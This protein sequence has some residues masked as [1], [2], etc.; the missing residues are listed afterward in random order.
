MSVRQVLDTVEA[1][2]KDPAEGLAATI[3]TLTLAVEGEDAGGPWTM[4]VQT[5]DLLL[6]FIPSIHD[7]AVPVLGTPTLLP[8]RTGYALDPGDAILL[9]RPLFDRVINEGAAGFTLMLAVR[10]AA[11]VGTNYQA[12]AYADPSGNGAVY[13][14]LVAG[15]DGAHVRISSGISYNTVDYEWI[16]DAGAIP[17][18]AHVV[19]MRF[20]RASAILARLDWFVDGVR[21]TTGARHGPVGSVDA[22]VLAGTIDT[23][24]DGVVAIGETPHWDGVP[25]TPLGACWG[26][27]APLNDSA[28]ALASQRALE[29]DAVEA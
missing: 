9:D 24:P 22:G 29:H 23:Y 11:L 6:E 20:T 16:D 15:A 5:D 28:I 4:D 18:G 14:A 2:L 8:H 25:N 12:L 21:V 19:A 1:L 17:L 26:W 7:G 10:S 27:K 13:L 3:E